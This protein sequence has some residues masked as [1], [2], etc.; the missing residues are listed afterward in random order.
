MSVTQYGVQF[1]CDL[2]G[3]VANMLTGPGMV[4]WDAL[5]KPDGWTSFTP[6]YNL[7]FTDLFGL[8]LH[9]L[10][11]VCGALS[12]SA[13]VERLRAKSEIMKAKVS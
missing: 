4:R 2:C 10:C 8:E 9:H 1:R 3:A 11:Q 13:L 5:P 7:S 6:D 12:I